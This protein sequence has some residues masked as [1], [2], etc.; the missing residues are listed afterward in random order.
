MYTVDCTY[1]RLLFLKSSFPAFIVPG[2]PSDDAIYIY[3]HRIYIYAHVC[4]YTR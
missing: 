3:T 4:M 1:P 2:V